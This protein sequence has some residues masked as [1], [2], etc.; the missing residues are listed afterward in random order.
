LTKCQPA[1]QEILVIDSSDGDDVTTLVDSFSHAG[2]RRLAD[3]RGGT[4]KAAN[5]GLRE[6][7][8]DAVLFTHDDCVVSTDWIGTGARLMEIYPGSIITG[9]VFPKG[10]WRTIPGLATSPHP[11]DYTGTFGRVLVAHN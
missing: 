5:L 6:A 9:G 7:T 11:R 1:A 2:A 4:A 10:D 3:S 8:H